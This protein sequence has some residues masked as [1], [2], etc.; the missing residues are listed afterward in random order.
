MPSAADMSAPDSELELEL[1]GDKLIIFLPKAL[2]VLL[3]I[4]VL[5]ILSVSKLILEVP[6]AFL[7][8]N[9][10]LFA[11]FCGV[12]DK[13]NF[14]WSISRPRNSIFCVVVNTDFFKLM[15]NPRC[16][17]KNISVN[18]AVIKS[19]IV[20]P[21]KRILYRWFITRVFNLLNIDGNFNNL[22]NILVAGP[23]PKHR[24]KNS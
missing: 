21:K 11:S 7:C 15:M 13:V 10:W 19:W 16:R 24:H 22:I 4:E 12:R 2:T 1:V 14:T 9:D 8:K 20:T 3:R 6:F 23:N 18:L 17:S 5:S